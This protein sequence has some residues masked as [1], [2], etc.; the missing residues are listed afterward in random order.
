MNMF[1]CFLL[2]LSVQLVKKIESQQAAAGPNSETF[3]D[4][5][6]EDEEGGR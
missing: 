2:F 4:V 1:L 6:S 5:V 3:G